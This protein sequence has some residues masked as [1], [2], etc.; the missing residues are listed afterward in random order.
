MPQTAAARD[1]PP[2]LELLCLQALWRLGEGNVADV[3][4][5]LAE[6]KSLAYTTVMTIL[7]RLAKKG[8]VER[9]K[10]GRAYVYAPQVTREAIQQQALSDFVRMHFGA[11]R[12]QL[13]AF[14]AGPQELPAA[15]SEVEEAA[16]GNLDP[17][18]L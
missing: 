6:T 8:F 5:T 13:L 15:I 18:L 4:Q 1:V 14:L 3:R 9:R 12:T 7:D 10:S 17:A 16:D 2:P 11:S